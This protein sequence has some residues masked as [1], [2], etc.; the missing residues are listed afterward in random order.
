MGLGRPVLSS[1]EIKRLLLTLSDESPRCDVDPYRNLLPAF[2]GIREDNRCLQCAD[3]VLGLQRCHCDRNHEELREQADRS[4]K[5]VALPH[6]HQQPKNAHNCQP[7]C[8][9]FPFP[10]PFGNLLSILYM[11]IN[12]SAAQPPACCPP[13]SETPW[14]YNPPPCIWLLLE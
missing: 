12:M 8:N 5:Q 4:A 10:D 2:I 6:T 11:Y 7:H 13:F 9:L 1:L 3:C 14:R